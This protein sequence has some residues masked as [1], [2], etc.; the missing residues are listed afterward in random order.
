MKSKYEEAVTQMIEDSQQFL[1]PIIR[2]YRWGFELLGA[3][4]LIYVFYHIGRLSNRDPTKDKIDK[5]N[6]VEQNKEKLTAKENA[7]LNRIKKIKWL[8]TFLFFVI[9]AL[10]VALY[11]LPTQFKL[12]LIKANLTPLNNL[13]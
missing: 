3:T 8:L 7:S 4:L 12:L 11:A 5:L 2:D 6:S 1:M 10:N 13:T 9:L